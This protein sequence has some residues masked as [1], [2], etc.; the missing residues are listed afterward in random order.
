MVNT[1]HWFGPLGLITACSSNHARGCTDS[2]NIP[3]LCQEAC[4]RCFSSVLVGPVGHLPCACV[5]RLVACA[6]GPVRG[7]PGKGEDRA[8]QA[9][10]KKV[11]RRLRKAG[12]ACGGFKIN[13]LV[14]VRVRVM[15][16]ACRKKLKRR[17]QTPCLRRHL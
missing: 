2:E 4:W 1:D 6:L 14:R 13:N 15:L 7:K 5:A 10:D 17:G 8:G 12:D 11:N 16:G 9:G 3:F